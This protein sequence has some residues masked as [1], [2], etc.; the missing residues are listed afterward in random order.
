MQNRPFIVFFLFLLACSTPEYLPESELNQYIVDTSNGVSR[1]RQIGSLEMMLTYKPNDFLKWQE[2]EEVSDTIVA[3]RVMRQYDQYV[4]F[5]LQLSVADKDALYATSSSQYDFSERL[6]NIAFRMG[7]FVNMTT[8]AQDT[9]PLA[10]AYYA[11]MFGMSKSTDVLL[12]FNSEKVANIDWISINMKDF[13]FRTGNQTFRF[14]V[15][16]IEKVPKLESLRPFYTMLN[17]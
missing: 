11:R 3:G 12:V 16:D 6:Q 9:I 1:A 8:S 4:Y 17:L 13:G 10:D 7:Q 5:V 15:Q 14:K 2:L